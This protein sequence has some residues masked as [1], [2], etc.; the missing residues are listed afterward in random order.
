MTKEFLTSLAVPAIGLLVALVGG[1][2]RF[3]GRRKQKSAPDSKK[4]GRL[5]KIGLVISVFGIWFFIVKLLPVIFG[6]MPSKE[7]T[8]EISPPRSGLVIAGYA[9]SSTIITTWIVMAV[10]IVLALVIRVFVLT[11]MTAVPKGA[12]NIM[13]LFVDSA[14][15]YTKSQTEGFG[16]GLSAYIF[17][18]AML[19][20]ACAFAELFGA[21]APTADITMTFALALITFI[22]INYYA[23]KKK[24]IWGRIKSLAK[25]TPVVMPFKIISDCAIPV[26]MACRLFGNMLGGMIVM[27]LLY[28][29]LGSS[30]VAIPSIVGIYFNVFHPIIQ[31]FIFITLTLTFINEAAE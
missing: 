26:S 15:G 27:D 31:T 25:P 7:F 8:V 20:V 12:Q 17:S 6:P 2:M 11:R 4:T 16:E 28:S 29:A 22:L 18:V 10:L 1:V 3:I 9:V 14:K 13:E 19:M 24:N 21:R 5:A 30:A 23:I